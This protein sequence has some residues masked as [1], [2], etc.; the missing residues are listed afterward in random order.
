MVFI[1]WWV[2]STLLLLIFVF[3]IHN[4]SK[5]TPEEYFEKNYTAFNSIAHKISEIDVWYNKY[6]Y[7]DGH[8]SVWVV[9]ENNIFTSNQIPITQFD[10][11]NK[12]RFLWVEDQ[13]KTLSLWLFHVYGS[14][15]YGI[16]NFTNKNIALIYSSKYVERNIPRITMKHLTWNW[17][18]QYYK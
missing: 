18:I 8:I 11:L 15:S 17:Y 13:L 2:I 1:M 16:T 14:W 5:E 4:T 6:Y 10:S 3:W 12:D 7:Y 9:D